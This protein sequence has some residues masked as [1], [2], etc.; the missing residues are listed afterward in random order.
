MNAKK[1]LL[2]IF[3]ILMGTGYLTAQDSPKDRFSIGPRLGINFSNVSEIEGSESATGIVGGLTSTYSINENTGLTIDL[4]YS[5]EGWKGPGNNPEVDL[6][7]LQIPI[8]FNYFF[9][10]QGNRFRPK[11]YVG[12]M[13]S[14]YL[15]GKVD[16]EDFDDD[17]INGFLLAVGGGLGF[18]YRVGQ[19]IWLNT[20]LRSNLG[21]SEVF[22][23]EVG[24][25]SKFRTVQFS[26]GLAYGLAK[27][28]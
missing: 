15:N 5:E 12:V 4:L 19:R 8:Y 9:G 28:E 17:N 1:F 3:V 27:Y 7:Y 18:N 16:G 10:E 23:A 25:P 14:F 11:V 2:M 22:E 20:D 6:R 13:P 21:L 24:E 26:V